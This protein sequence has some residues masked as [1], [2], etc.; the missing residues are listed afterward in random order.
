MRADDLPR[1]V[2]LINRTH[3]GLDL[4]RPYTVDFLESHLDD[5]AWGPKPAFWS[6]VFGWEDYA[7]VEDGTGAVVACG[8]LW[9]RGRD[10]RE[11]WRNEQTGQERTIEATALLDWGYEPGRADAMALLLRSFLGRTA[12]LGRSHLLAPF[13]HT[14]DVAALVARARSRAGGASHP[15]HDVPGRAGPGGRR[16]DEALHR[17]R[18][19]VMAFRFDA[20]G[21]IRERPPLTGV[22]RRIGRFVLEFRG[23]VALGLGLSAVST[24]LFVLLPFP[25]KWLI[26]GVLIGDSLEPGTLRRCQ[27]GHHR[28]EADGRRVDRGR[29]RRAVGGPGRH[30]RARRSTSS[31]ARRC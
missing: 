21:P 17:P 30:Q 28:R 13:E 31:P 1:C 7:V 25:I 23:G 5:P 8:G 29:L 2:E 20:D 3:E 14:P 24:L 18:V 11:V 27:H 26:D 15:H 6:P 9:D 22:Y 10:I 16:A 19:L 4:F 12:D